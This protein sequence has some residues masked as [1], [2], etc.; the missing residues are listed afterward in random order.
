M[1]H[2]GLLVALSIAVLLAAPLVATLLSRSPWLGWSM[3]SFVLVTVGGIVVLHVVP[4]S[5]A[6]AGPRAIVAACIGLFL[7]IL[8]HRLDAGVLAR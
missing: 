8:L 4:Q 2:G 5:A 7:P 3:D 1:S 6:L